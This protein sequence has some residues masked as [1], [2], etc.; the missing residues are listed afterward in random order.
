MESKTFLDLSKSGVI[1]ASA[2][3]GKTWTINEICK[4]LILGKRYHKLESDEKID[5]CEIGEIL[6]V[7]FTNA[8][9]A[10]LRERI[11]NGIEEALEKAEELKLSDEEK[12]RLRLAST[13]FDC[14]HISTIHSFCKEIL[15]T[16]STECGLPENVVVENEIEEQRKYFAQKFVSAQILAG[17]LDAETFGGLEMLVA[18]TNKIWKNQE[19]CLEELT[20]C[21]NAE[22]LPGYKIIMNEGF[23]AWCNFRE[24]K[25]IET[26][27]ISA[28]ESLRILQK[29]L[30]ENEMLAQ[31]IAKRYKVA[32]VDEAQDTDSIQ[33]DIFTR[34]F[35][36]T[37]RRLFFIGDPKQA[38]YSFRGADV[39][40]YYKMK[41]EILDGNDNLFTLKNNYRSSLALVE[42]VNQLFEGEPK[43]LN[44]K[45]VAAGG[46]I[47][48]NDENLFNP[49]G[50]A[51]DVAD[52]EKGFFYEKV[53]KTSETLVNAVTKLVVEK[54]VPANRIAVLTR[55]NKSLFKLKDALA[56][57]GVPATCIKDSSVYISKEATLFDYLLRGIAG[58]LKGEELEFL[59]YGA[60][61][62]GKKSL[63]DLRGILV[64]ARN[65]WEREGILA[66]FKKLNEDFSIYE[67]LAD[68]QAV[69]NFEQLVELT[70]RECRLKQLGLSQ[71]IENLSKKISK[72]NADEDEQKMRLPTSAPAVQL[73][74]IHSSKGLEYDIVF[75]L[76]LEAGEKDSDFVISEDRKQLIFEDAD[77]YKSANESKKLRDDA[78]NIYVALTRA[79]Y[80]C[81]VYVK[82]ERDSYFIDLL[83]AARERKNFSW[84]QDSVDL[85]FIAKNLPPPK[86]DAGTQKQGEIDLEAIKKND[87]A[88]RERI[89]KERCG[90]S[91]Y[92]SLFKNTQ[93]QGE[94]VDE[95]L[96]TKTEDVAENNEPR[97]VRDANMF[98]QQDVWRDL[99]AGTA[100][101]IAIH[102]IFESID[103]ANPEESIDKLIVKTGVEKSDENFEKYRALIL[104]TLQNLKIVDEKCLCDFDCGNDVLREL[105]FYLSVN[106]KDKFFIKLGELLRSRGDIYERTYNRFFKN[107]EASEKTLGWMMKGFIDVI[108]RDKDTG[109]YYIVDWKTNIVKKDA[110][111]ISL[112][113]IE[114]E[115]VA[116]GYALQWLFYCVAWRAF[117]R[118]QGRYERGKTLGGVRYV[119]V[120]W[121]AVYEA[122]IDDDF[123]DKLEE[124]LGTIKQ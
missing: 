88:L 75:L 51:G 100:F 91:S 95:F 121:Q 101:G 13:S 26:T 36:E 21:G 105:E 103:F 55:D 98:P 15:N 10:E 45:I 73:S 50:K 8:A 109:K 68:K 122:T 37:G 117:L 17:A 86:E 99:P 108:L 47:G 94:F 79:K 70:A 12:I 28:N 72:P 112:L 34:I 110:T 69:S 83:K 32:I 78:C 53:E 74:T 111:Q 106:K 2:G 92:S 59:R 65:A 52:L 25:S 30:K 48:K 16:F 80:F 54:R 14:A 87:D 58:K 39:N 82:K 57:K 107:N 81:V 22:R 33:A 104:K 18:T 19:Q 41:N 89:G 116:H 11:Q 71:A 113:E 3:T 62:S 119:F 123:L 118:E 84:E 76:G 24:Q 1:D 64:E 9:T 114:D 93:A 77:N 20:A 38:I 5:L 56:E 63:E 61:F 7:T 27:T 67:N 96:E 49:C 43:L 85:D 44:K 4:K 90:L 60:L 23:N 42:G 120:R 40:A 31:K 29:A 46:T 115:I 66:A 6:V 102:E 97:E 35:L 124:I